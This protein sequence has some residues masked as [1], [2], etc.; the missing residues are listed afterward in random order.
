MNARNRIHPLAVCL[1]FAAGGIVLDR[2][3]SFSAF[4][5]TCFLI[6][7][8]L[9]YSYLHA[10]TS[11]PIW[12]DSPNGK[13]RRSVFRWGPSLFVSLALLCFFGYL[14]HLY[15]NHY[16]ENDIGFYAS[17]DSSPVCLR[18]RIVESAFRIPVPP[19]DPGQIIAVQEKIG[20]VIRVLEVRN[21]EHWE[22]L[23]GRCMVYVEGKSPLP[24]YGDTLLLYGKLSA[25]SEPKNP[26]DFNVKN[27]MRSRRILSI[28]RV[29][30]M[31]SVQREK[32]GTICVARILESVRRNAQS[33]LK[34]YMGESGAPLATAMILGYRE[35]VE[36]GTEQILL[37][38]G[39]MHIL[40]ISGLHVGLIAGF[41][42][43]LFRFLGVSRKKTA[44]GMIVILLLYFSLTDQRPPAL[45]A[46]LL[47]CIASFAVLVGRKPLAINTL[48]ATALIVLLR[49]PTELFQFGAQLSFLATSVFIWIPGAREIFPKIEEEII[50]KRRR[51]RHWIP[52]LRKKLL[53]FFQDIA[54]LFFVSF[55]LTT[56]TL[57][58]LLDRI[59]LI[60]PVALLVNPLLWIPLSFA[61]VSGFFTM[62][63]AWICPPIAWIT[64][65]FGTWSFETLESMLHFFHEIPMGHF[66]F[67][68]PASWWLLGFYLPLTLLTLFPTLRP[69]RR[70]IF[71]GFAIWCGVGF[72]WGY[73]RD[74]ERAYSQRLDIRVLS[75]GHGTSVLMLTPE[76]KTLIYDAG[77]FSRPAISANTLSQ[78]LWKAGKTRIDAIVLSHPDSDHFNAVPMLAERFRIQNVYISPYMFQKENDSV[79]HLRKTLE[80]YR[81]PVHFIG[82]GDSIDLGSTTVF[83][84]LHPGK[85]K[86][87]G[88]KR[89]NM[90]SNST[91]VVL[92]VEHLEKRFLFPGDLEMKRYY[93]EVDF[94]D[95]SPI[96]CE[97]LM[98]PHHGGH[99]NLTEPLLRWSSPRSL[100]ISGGQFTYKPE[101]VEDFQRR[102][103][104]VF[105]T[106]NDGCIHIA[107]DQ[108]KC[109]IRTFLNRTG[110]FFIPEDAEDF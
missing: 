74:W 88:V 78:S 97:M 96:A 62:I 81:V 10:I 47:I 46:T 71:L 5:W 9:G 16:H 99:S 52:F 103:F 24:Q 50:L 3:F 33:N 37:K 90:E 53:F 72:F 27:R 95:Q 43:L 79:E 49:N 6:V 38:T 73:A 77:S 42:Y 32:T 61:L 58:L 66:W 108:E 25:P 101:L 85:E 54:H 70:T 94:L 67:P 76:G 75:I 80:N 60:T 31:D 104:H 92:L 28:L 110:N 17:P 64:G 102:G 13:F 83:T 55:V 26:G 100:L 11:R 34:K 30:S 59:H 105:H 57:P 8:L 87:S 45:R 39:T 29:D 4:D 35:D 44:L 21:G 48:C 106:L 89:N 51:K 98:L 107:V 18:G 65:K 41:L 86:G 12:W 22:P 36:F 56:I 91:S 68:G 82:E 93:A 40:A 84:I 7:S 19:S 15:W 109:E 23:N 14:H 63:F 1:V 20:F 2:V 69:G